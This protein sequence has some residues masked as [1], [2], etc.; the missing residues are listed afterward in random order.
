MT[1]P[2]VLF[3]FFILLCVSTFSFENALLEE[4]EKIN[5]IL[6]KVSSNPF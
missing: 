6:K 3:L 5:V 2:W 1:R 4:L